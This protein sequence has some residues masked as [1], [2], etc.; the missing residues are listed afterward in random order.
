M[1][2]TR[3]LVTGGGRGIGRAT[4]L[5]FARE[6]AHVS[7]A[8]RTSSELDEVVGEIE[9]AGGKGHAAQMDVR[10]FGSVEAA[11]WRSVDFLGGSIDV[12]VNNAGVFDVIPFEKLTPAAW[13]EHIAV[14]LDGCFFVVKEAFDALRSSGKA[15]VFNMASVAA[16]QGFPGNAAYCASKYGLR[17]FS[18]GLREDF[19]PL[20]IKVSTVYPSATDTKIFDRVPGTWDRTKMHRPEQV[21]E[22]IWNAW[23]APPTTNTNDL[24]V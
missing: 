19:T 12:L 2:Q 23:T 17:G 11:V 14:N 7:I 6:G 20:G 21:A 4:A 24:D 1:T 10:D 16:R 8:A 3:V 22:V 15:H 13:Q 18:D 5:R 9:R